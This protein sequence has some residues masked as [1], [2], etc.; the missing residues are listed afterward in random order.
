[1]LLLQRGRGGSSHLRLGLVA[2]A[3]GCGGRATD[4][5]VP[6]FE[7]SVGGRGGANAGNDPT[8]SAGDSGSGPLGPWRPGAGGRS[9]AGGT[10]GTGT[11]A[12]VG[13]SSVSGNF[14]G[15]LGIAGGNDGFEPEAVTPN[16]DCPSDPMAL[17]E[18][19]AALASA[20]AAEDPAVR[21]FIRYVSAGPLRTTCSTSS[22]RSLARPRLAVNK[23]SNSVSLA[24]LPVPVRPLDPGGLL[25]RI[26]LRDYGWNRPVEVNGVSYADGWEAIVA[27]APLAHEFVGGDADSLKQLVGALIPWL[28]AS[29]FVAAA[30]TSDVYYALTAAP[31]TLAELKAQLGISRADETLAG[32]WWRSGFSNS[33]VSRQDRGVARYAGAS[34]G[35]SMFWQTFD[36]AP[37]TALPTLFLE[38][39]TARADGSEVIYSLPNGLP[40]YFVVDGAERRANEAALLVDPAVGGPPRVMASC[41]SCHNAGLVTFD[42]AVRAFVEANI[43]GTFT[44]DET[45]AVRDAYPPNDVMHSQLESDSSRLALALSQAGQPEG[46]P[47]TVSRVVLEYQASV[48]PEVVAGELYVRPEALESELARLPPVLSTAL[49]TNGL[50]R[51]AF[52]AS[53]H[54]ALCALRAGPIVPV[55]CP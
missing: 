17:E 22:S 29:S 39:L 34:L 42:D 19:V 26:D 13:G 38:P 37:N 32:S 46:W 54:D 27:H 24:P 45:Q 9:G 48:A 14:G 2:L 52:E 33:G 10:N 25:L 7:G 47:D 11:P 20:A 4:G 6:G 40:A 35:T 16:E 1:M 49:A 51:P 15:S 3:L 41:G 23:V 43:A 53:Y 44:P 12:G 28:L 31:S 5:D 18:T 55:G 30:S 21:G 36:Y 50:A 8:A